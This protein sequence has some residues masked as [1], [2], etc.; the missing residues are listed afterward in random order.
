MTDWH[1]RSHCNRTHVDKGAL[2]YFY[3]ELKCRSLLDIGCGPGEMVFWAERIGFRPAN[4]VDGDPEV[5]ATWTHDFLS[6][7]LFTSPE[8]ISYDIAWCN[9]FL[10]HI[11][12]DKMENVW[13][14][15]EACKY[16]AITAHP[17]VTGKQRFR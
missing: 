10:E 13:P 3:N 14:C 12:A 4:G 9:E 16:A 17:I 15:F 7:P 11:P 1:N 2:Y 8:F 5:K 6:E